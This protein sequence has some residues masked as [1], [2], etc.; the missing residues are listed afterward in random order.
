MQ[1]DCWGSRRRSGKVMARHSKLHD[2]RNEGNGSVIIQC[3][4]PHFFGGLVC[5]LISSMVLKMIVNTGNS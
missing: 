3:S 5:W 4:D 1:A 2:H